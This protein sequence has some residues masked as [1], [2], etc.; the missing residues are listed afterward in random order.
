MF[1]IVKVNG[2]LIK[3]FATSLEIIQVKLM[4]FIF[5]NKFIKLNI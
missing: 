2:L 1:Q 4:E 5:R 3:D